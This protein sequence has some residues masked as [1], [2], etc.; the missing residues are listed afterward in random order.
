MDKN[1]EKTNDNNE[2]DLQTSRANKRNFF[3]RNCR[4]K[5]TLFA[6]FVG[7]KR[8]GLFRR[9]TYKNFVVY[10]LSRRNDNGLPGTQ[11]GCI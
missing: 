4:E 2:R 10:Y 5:W 8:Y 6:G 7:R 1:V 11:G 3:V 9:S